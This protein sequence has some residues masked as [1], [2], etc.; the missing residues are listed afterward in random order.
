MTF[1]EALDALK[2]GKRVA[3]AGWNGN[4]MWLLLINGWTVDVEY[5]TVLHGRLPIPW[6]GLKTVRDEFVPWVA[7]Q[8]DVL[9]KDWMEV[10]DA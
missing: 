3:R 8:T 6:I 4:G 7:S 9:A 1:G 5:E 10:D 2:A